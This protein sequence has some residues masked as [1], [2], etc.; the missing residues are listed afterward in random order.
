M[1]S[2]LTIQSMG[3]LFVVQG[4]VTR[5]HADA[6]LLPTDATLRVSE[7]WTAPLNER[8][9]GVSGGIVQREPPARWGNQDV[10]AFEL[11]ARSSDGPA[12]VAVNTGGSTL[13]DPRWYLTGVSEAVAGPRT[14]EARCDS[15]SE[16]AQQTRTPVKRSYRWLVD[17]RRV[18]SGGR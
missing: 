18:R 4:D 9:I 8:G 12:V 2:F 17:P 5:I 14:D 16:D 13:S 3:H 10:R 6:W 11:V 15:A 1:A 7:G